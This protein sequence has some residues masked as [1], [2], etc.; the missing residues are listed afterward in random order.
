MCPCSNCCPSQKE[1]S[2]TNVRSAWIY[3]YKYKCFKESL[4]FLLVP[5]IGA[6]VVPPIT[7]TYVYQTFLYH[8][9]WGESIL[10]HTFFLATC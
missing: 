6:C 10:T 2:V 9:L 8:T 3:D 5:A 1:A 7:P 4:Y